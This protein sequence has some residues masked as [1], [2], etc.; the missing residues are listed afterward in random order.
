L[1]ND[2]LDAIWRI[3]S[4]KIIAGL[5][6][7]V[8]DLG[9]AEELAQDAFVAAL[10]QW[11]EQG[12][13]RNPGAWLMTAAKRRAIDS[14]RR[15][16]SF[17]EKLPALE[18][19]AKSHD[20]ETEYAVAYEEIDD[21][22]LRLMFISC[23]S[24]LSTEARVALTLRMIGGLTTPEI[25]RAFMIAEPAL[26]QR[27]V[28]AKRTLSEAHVPFEVPMGADRAARV[29][30][31]LEVLYLI[32]NEGY[33]ATA[34]DDILRPELV[35]DALRLGRVLA[36]LM[37][38]ETEVHGLLALME[39]Q[40]SRFA[41]R[42]D[43]KGAPILLQ[44]QNRAYWNRMLIQRGLASLATAEKLGTLGPYSLQASIS[45]CHA[46]AGTFED[47][48]W[49]RIVAFYDA[50]WQLQPTPVVAL[51]RAVAL[52]M[53]YGPQAGL[54]AVVPLLAEPALARYHLLPAVQGDMLMRLERYKEASA[55][56]SNAAE[57]ATNPRDR[58]FLLSRL[59]ECREL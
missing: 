1:L 18:H 29:A 36:G 10:A 7:I 13:P 59:K 28:R 42:V 2:S 12:I 41:T 26:A 25:A 5:M 56:F 34:G 46:R 24:V 21:D 8:R 19:D 33:S 14:I 22:L 32:F 31:V 9:R 52:G 47:T 38:N 53:A 37:P 45:A 49:H 27:I 51:N 48:D 20:W 6:R 3:E 30:S 57:L 4:P 15:A 40:A 55:A 44:D 35:E 58:E 11:P 17:E 39:L 23:H 16:K 50:L 54:D 43:A